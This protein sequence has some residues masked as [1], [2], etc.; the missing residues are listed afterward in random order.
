MLKNK[1]LICIPNLHYIHYVGGRFKPIL[2]YLFDSFYTEKETPKTRRVSWWTL[3]CGWTLYS[4]EIEIEAPKDEATL[5][6]SF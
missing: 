6:F 2:Y 3:L 5:Q 4:I 1:D